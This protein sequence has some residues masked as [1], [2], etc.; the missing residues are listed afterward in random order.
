MTP[1]QT[2]E[3]HDA[4]HKTVVSHLKKIIGSAPAKGALTCGFARSGTPICL[5]RVRRLMFHL[6]AGMRRNH[7]EAQVLGPVS[8]REDPHAP[9]AVVHQRLARRPSS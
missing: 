4:L 1:E 7:S 6:A 9:A 8:K 3:L 5:P 2:R